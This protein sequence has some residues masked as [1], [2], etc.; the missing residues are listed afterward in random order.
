[1]IRILK[2]GCKDTYAAYSWSESES[3]DNGNGANDIYKTIETDVSN[4]GS[5][6]LCQLSEDTHQRCTANDG[7]KICCDGY[8]C[9][10]D[11]NEYCITTVQQYNDD[12]GRNTRRKCRAY[13][14]CAVGASTTNQK[15][16]CGDRT[17]ESGEYCRVFGHTGTCS[18]TEVQNGVSYTLTPNKCTHL[19]DTY[20][21][22][23]LDDC[24][25]AIQFLKGSFNS[26]KWYYADVSEKYKNWPVNKLKKDGHWNKKANVENPSNTDDYPAILGS[27]GLGCFVKKEN[28]V[29]TAAFDYST[30]TSSVIGSCFESDDDINSREDWL[31]MTRDHKKNTVNTSGWLLPYDYSA[32]TYKSQFAT[33]YEES[34][35]QYRTLSKST[36]RGKSQYCICAVADEESRCKDGDNDINCKCGHEL[37]TQHTG[38]ICRKA[39]GAGVNDVRQCWPTIYRNISTDIFITS[40][41]CKNTEGH[42]PIVNAQTCKNTIETFRDVL[43]LGGLNSSALTITDKHHGMKSCK[44]RHFDTGIVRTSLDEVQTGYDYVGRNQKYEDIELTNELV[45]NVNNEHFANEGMVRDYS[46]IDDTYGVPSFTDVHICK[47]MLSTDKCS[48]SKNSNCWCV[49]SEKFKITPTITSISQMNTVAA[50]SNADWLVTLKEGGNITIYDSDGTHSQDITWTECEYKS[51]AL[52][53]ATIVV[54]APSCDKV[55]VYTHDGSTWSR[56]KKILK[57]PMSSRVDKTKYAAENAGDYFPRAVKSTRLSNISFG[58][59]VA[60]SS[61]YI[62]VGAPDNMLGRPKDSE[63]RS[64]YAKWG[65]DGDKAPSELNNF[66]PFK[67]RVYIFKRGDLNGVPQTLEKSCNDYDDTNDRNWCNEC[68]DWNKDSYSPNYSFKP[69]CWEQTSN[70]EQT[71]NQ[72]YRQKWQH[73]TKD[74]NNMPTR[75]PNGQRRKEHW[76]DKKASHTREEVELATAIN[77]PLNQEWRAYGDPWLSWQGNG[78]MASTLKSKRTQWQ[79]YGTWWKQGYKIWAAETTEPWVIDR[80]GPDLDVETTLDKCQIGESHYEIWENKLSER[81]RFKCCSKDSCNLT[82]QIEIL[83]KV[84]EI[85]CN[86]V[87]NCSSFD[88]V[89]TGY[90]RAPLRNTNKREI[91][92]ND[93]YRKGCKGEIVKHRTKPGSV[94]GTEYYYLDDIWQLYK[95][96]EVAYVN[97]EN[98]VNEK[99][100]AIES[101]IG[102][103]SLVEWSFINAMGNVPFT[104]EQFEAQAGNDTKLS[105]I[106]FDALKGVVQSST[107][108]GLYKD[109]SKHA[110][111]L[112]CRPGT[113]KLT[114]CKKKFDY[115]LDGDKETRYDSGICNIDSIALFKNLEFGSSVAVE[116]DTLVVNSAKGTHIYSMVGTDIIE[117]KTIAGDV[118]DIDIKNGFIVHSLGIYSKEG[119]TE[120]SEK[121]TFD[122]PAKHVSI[123]QQNAI[124][125]SE[126]TVQL[127]EIDFVKRNIQ[128]PSQGL[129][130]VDKGVVTKND[131]SSSIYNFGIVGSNGVFW[132]ISDDKIVKAIKETESSGDKHA[133]A[134]TGNQ[135]CHS[136]HCVVDAQCSNIDATQT[137]S[138]SC[139]CGTSGII[140]GDDSREYIRGN[141]CQKGDYCLESN[142]MCSPSPMCSHS[143]VNQQCL[144]GLQVCNSREYCDFTDGRC[145]SEISELKE[146]SH[147]D[148]KKENE[149]TM[150]RCGSSACFNQVLNSPSTGNYH[151]MYC[152][153]ESNTCSV[154]P[155][156]VKKIMT[157]QHYIAETE[158]KSEYLCMHVAENMED[159]PEIK[160]RF[161][162]YIESKSSMPVGCVYDSDARV[163]YLNTMEY[164]HVDRD[165]RGTHSSGGKLEPIYKNTWPNPS[166]VHCPY[167]WKCLTIDKSSKNILGTTWQ[168]KLRNGSVSENCSNQRH[169]GCFNGKCTH[170]RNC[171]HGANSETCYCG[172]EICY[173]ADSNPWTIPRSYVDSTQNYLWCN[174]NQGV[175]S[176]STQDPGKETVKY[177]WSHV[178]F[179][180]ESY[181]A[182]D[183]IQVGQITLKEDCATF[184]SKREYDFENVADSTAPSGCHM[185]LKKIIQGSEFS[186]YRTRSNYMVTFNNESNEIACT[187]HIY[188]K[189]DTNWVEAIDKLCIKQELKECV[190]REYA[191]TPCKCESLNTWNTNVCFK[192][193]CIRGQCKAR[194]CLS[195]THSMAQYMTYVKEKTDRNTTTCNCG[196]SNCADDD[197]EGNFACKN[198][199]CQR[200][201]CPK[202]DLSVTNQLEH[203]CMCNNDVCQEGQFCE[204]Y[205]EVIVSRCTHFYC[206]GQSL[207]YNTINQRCVDYTKRMPNVDLTNKN[208]AG[209]DL[210]GA[211]LTGADLTGADLTGAD[212][213]GADLTGTSLIGSNFMS[214]KLNNVMTRNIIGIPK[215]L[216]EGWIY[217]KGYLIPYGDD[218]IPNMQELLDNDIDTHIEKIMGQYFI[219]LSN[220]Q[221]CLIRDEKIEKWINTNC[222]NNLTASIPRLDIDSPDPE[223][224]P[225]GWTFIRRGSERYIVGH[226]LFGVITDKGYIEELSDIFGNIQQKMS[227][228]TSSSHISDKPDKIYANTLEDCKH[229]AADA[230]TRDTT[231]TDI[232]GCFKEDNQYVFVTGTIEEM[233]K[234][235]QETTIERLYFNL[236]NI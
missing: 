220:M 201:T 186:Y 157:T 90:N 216:P 115:Q 16:S 34:I 160:D 101:S 171:A 5:F 196:E 71:S 144:C 127:Y 195:D 183:D 174:L 54:G 70:R 150:C 21:L 113:R 203:K 18:T 58:W 93:P 224:L 170:I 85:P 110:E 6:C 77:V 100:D 156:D 81:G 118:S 3:L 187:Q 57:P 141:R 20:Q 143:L 17:C 102:S 41:K 47:I 140:Y 14:A 199:Q 231:Y 46:F 92:R 142:K 137:L 29:V 65:G 97:C 73:A 19:E 194:E 91:W 230:P 95:K 79:P 190:D 28:G 53:N 219:D 151:G 99:W 209:A 155:R 82:D 135:T 80:W 147:S 125:S 60:I 134:C 32:V 226:N 167:P 207:T 96:E 208:L 153:K 15:C 45:G 233:R 184:A 122:Q 63:Q 50:K 124:V 138:E 227:K 132:M 105:Q 217:M 166:N 189:T 27:G 117:E 120:W 168:C 56:K 9:N 40:M 109:Q 197:L 106:E 229:I 33:G 180:Q 8:Y 26:S 169:L 176:C 182:V 210:R 11:I 30:V 213:T 87:V 107:N 173:K 161:A 235:I 188:N 52:D 10:S 7:N 86:C 234:N 76:Y 68:K 12:L 88:D 177:I 159:F 51:I 236:S 225:E 22:R 126:S 204:Y 200:V 129:D 222:A 130:T 163:M 111:A 121:I 89:V 13:S 49:P 154:N 119:E 133:M 83:Y 66:M 31:S 214:I 44:I 148:G 69:T 62:V 232:K 36:S 178:P 145:K 191:E 221:E 67:P 131:Y 74:S 42:Y 211:D 165:N 94:S 149:G 59:S 64:W 193:H 146:C 116:D 61:K 25:A 123:S 104:H 152:E 98:T 223:L 39:K 212:L 202:S 1:M 23:T 128:E 24:R 72:E 37:C 114:G 112:P 35:T 181:D 228:L 75:N 55:Y 175:G 136:G 38:R 78:K 162:V 4:F 172:T 179:I 158:L 139:V 2:P 43:Y 164:N 103:D 205:P 185:E 108:V 192:Q 215:S 206:R 198:G 48:S 84:Q 218:T